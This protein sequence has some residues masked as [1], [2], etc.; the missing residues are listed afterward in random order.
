MSEREKEK[1]L[2]DLFLK[3][4]NARGFKA[5]WINYHIGWVPRLV[6]GGY[7]DRLRKILEEALE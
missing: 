5:R 7:Y 3:A 4:G 6:K 1:H 2:A